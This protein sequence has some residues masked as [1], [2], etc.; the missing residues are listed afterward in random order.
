MTSQDTKPL[1]ISRQSL[2]RMPVY[3]ELLKKIKAGGGTHVSAAFLAGELGLHPVQVR[4][5]LA[6]VSKVDG[7]PRIGFALD[8]LIDDME[9]FLGCKNAH[10]AVVAGVG[11]L[12]RALLSY[13]GFGSYG[14]SII[15][16]FDTSPDVVGTTVA[17]KEIFHASRIAELC[18]R[19]GVHIGIIAAPAAAAQS[20]CDAM[21]R[22]G[23]RAIW[24]FAPVHLTL[25]P[26]VI[27]ANENLAASFAALS[28]RLSQMSRRD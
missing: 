28:G 18:A 13:G 19:L 6:S 26:G 11:N 22:G 2:Q 3:L 10:E 9:D 24:N 25:P 7:N 14:L 20:T 12:G 17:G 27:V 8:G 1:S 5:D 4:K 15:A 21:L 23:V 16:G